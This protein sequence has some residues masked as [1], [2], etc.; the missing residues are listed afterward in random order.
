MAGMEA[1]G[2]VCNVIPVAAGKPFKLRSASVAM[3]VCTGNDTFTINERTSFGGSN[4]AINVIKN[5]YWMTANDGTASWNK[6]TWVNTTTPLSAITLASGGAGTPT[7]LVNATCGVFHVF[8]S[9]LSDPNNY[10]VV[11]VGGAG[12][13]QAYLG[14][15]VHQRAPANLEILGA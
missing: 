3:F 4:T 9:E 5:I 15:L 11:T 2:R 1:L 14:D 7:S 8:T 6:F 12:L 13:V 10:L